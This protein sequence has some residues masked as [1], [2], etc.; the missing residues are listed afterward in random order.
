MNQATTRAWILNMCAKATIG[1][2][3]KPHSLYRL[4][5]WR[6]LTLGPLLL[7]L[8][9]SRCTTSDAKAHSR[10]KLATNDFGGI[11]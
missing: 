5:A 11:P 3:A 1:C 8:N 4:L 9:S 6:A 10:S 2:T 7:S